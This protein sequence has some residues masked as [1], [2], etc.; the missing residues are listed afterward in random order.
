MVGDV[1]IAK[2][3]VRAS[4]SLLEQCTKWSETTDLLQL[5]LQPYLIS[6]QQRK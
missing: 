3:E 5:D 6:R 4:Q 2:M 1:T